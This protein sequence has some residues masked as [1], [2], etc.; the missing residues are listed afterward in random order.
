MKREEII[1]MLR[2]F[3]LNEYDARVYSTLAILGPSRVGIISKKADVPQPKVYGVLDK[4]LDMNLV[5]NIGGRPK[6]F[7]AIEPEIAL[8]KLVDAKERE[9]KELHAKVDMLKDV[10]KPMGVRKEVVDGVW[11]TKG[12]GLQDFINRL[13]KMYDNTERYAYLI[14][15]DFTYNSKIAE[16]VKR[17]VRRGVKFRTIAMRGVDESNFYRAKWFHSH[18]VDVRVFKTKVHPRIF[19]VDGK[20]VLIRLDKSPTKRSRF[21]FTSIWSVDPSL[22]KVF[23]VYMKNIWKS[24]KPIDFKKLE[25]SLKL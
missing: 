2:M 23:E 6:E 15:R 9:A 4:L 13:A 18:G 16:S 12:R 14:S 17:G 19:V 11:T 1:G 21:E 20:E 24:A 3:G 25:K 22:T 10:L 8:K 7:R 5:E